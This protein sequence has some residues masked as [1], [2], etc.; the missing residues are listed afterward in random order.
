ME[1]NIE[2]T[3][4]ADVV[5]YLERDYSLFLGWEDRRGSLAPATSAAEYDR[6]LHGLR[7]VL[8]NHALLGY[9]CARLTPGEI[10]H[11]SAEG[12][13]LPNGEML[14]RRI[15][16][17]QASGFIEESVAR[18]FLQ[19]NQADEPNRAGRIW[20]CFFPP[21]MAGETGIESLLRYWGGEALYNSHDRHPERGG[22]LANLGVPCLVEADVPI[23]SLRGPSF[24][25]VKA[26]KQFL[27]WR[28]LPTTEPLEHED[29]SIRCI[30]AKNIRRIIQFPDA[31][32]ITL[33]CCD[34]WRSP[35]LTA[36][37]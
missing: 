26:V 5:A 15:E 14:R 18:E 9:H 17:V 8:N 2:R 36:N 35:L 25:D 21:F 28:G 24:L 32:F 1:L 10:S 7:D 12:M 11:I 33:T 34:T 20:F 6:A 27:A 37:W 30:P 22:I 4:P 13:Q 3:W 31:D 23:A 29:H 19:K 16:A